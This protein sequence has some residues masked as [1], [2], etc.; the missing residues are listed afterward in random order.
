MVKNNAILLNI[1]F[2]CLFYFKKIELNISQNKF[3]KYFHSKLIKEILNKIIYISL[4]SPG[5]VVSVFTS[6]YLSA[7]PLHLAKP[8]G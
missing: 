6:P 8:K 7:G 4:T 3:Y 5:E 1:I 2:S